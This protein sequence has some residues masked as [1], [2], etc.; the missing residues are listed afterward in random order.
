[1]FDFSHL[2]LDTARLRLRPLLPT[3]APAVH[4]LHADPEGM[5]YWSTPPW[6]DPAE[7]DALIARDAAALAAGDFIR[8]GLERRHH[9]QAGQDGRLIGL[10][11]LF[12]FHLPSRRCEVGYML[13][14]DCWGGGLMHEAL[15]ALLGFG[16]G[17]LDLNR[18][19]ADIDTRNTASERT[20]RR[21]GFQLEGTLRQR[22][23]VAG[24]VSDTG[25]YG[26]LRRDWLA[27]DAAAAPPQPR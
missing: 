21:L 15:K 11:S 27:R 2:V 12:A 4:A 19:E 1:M 8:L 13:A 18:V 14:R 26:L 24:E 6:T 3:D 5:R 23:I 7:A 16:F 20:L 17:V 22:W 9:G 10:C 25:L